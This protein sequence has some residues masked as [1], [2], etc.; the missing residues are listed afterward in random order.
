MWLQN[1][2]KAFEL[3]E[4]KYSDED[5][6]I[7]AGQIKFVN[8]CIRSEF[9]KII[10]LL[11]TGQIIDISDSAV[12][13]ERIKYSFD[14]VV[15]RYAEKNNMKKDLKV[16]ITPTDV[17]RIVSNISSVEVKDIYKQSKQFI[18]EETG[19]VSESDKC[20]FRRNGR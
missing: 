13:G 10:A 1:S 14:S 19:R 12:M 17:Q 18:D 4:R 8:E 7:T 6:Q 5:D 16:Q 9:K 2:K 11:K 20:T 15:K 3:A